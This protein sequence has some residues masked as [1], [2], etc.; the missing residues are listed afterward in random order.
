MSVELGLTKL[1]LQ[2][3]WNLVLVSRRS[4]FPFSFPF[5][6][7]PVPDLSHSPFFPANTNSHSTEVPVN[8]YYEYFGPD[9]RLDVRPNNME[10]LNTREYLEKIKIKFSNLYVTVDLLLQFKDTKNQDW[11]MIWLWKM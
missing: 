1:V 8:E 10:D 7:C 11:L 9:Y 2:L 5:L 6:I 4:F 3:E